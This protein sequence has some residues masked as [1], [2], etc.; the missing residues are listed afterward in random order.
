[1]WEDTSLVACMGVAHIIHIMTLMVVVPQH[2]YAFAYILGEFGMV[3][4]A[5]Y[6]ERNNRRA[7]R[8]SRN[9]SRISHQDI[10]VAVKVQKGKF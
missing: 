1:M 8:V 7:S 3:Y 9:A 5:A 10:F 6:V 2:Y 4:K